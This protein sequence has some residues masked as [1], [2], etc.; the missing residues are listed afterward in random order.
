MRGLLQIVKAYEELTIEAGV[1]GD[2]NAAIKALTIHPLVGDSGIAKKVLDDIIN[3][4]MAY[5]PQY[6][7]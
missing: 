3:E 2:Y 1:K 7:H 4:N 6:K 5:L